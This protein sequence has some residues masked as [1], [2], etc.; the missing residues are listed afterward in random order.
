MTFNVIVE[1]SEME[2]ESVHATGSDAERICSYESS[3]IGTQV[4]FKYAILQIA[5]V[6][7]KSQMYDKIGCVQ[8]RRYINLY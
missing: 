7:Q 8:P 1:H 3:P 5:M 6:Y 2:W 4:P